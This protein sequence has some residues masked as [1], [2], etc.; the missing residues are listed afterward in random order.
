MSSWKV[1]PALV[2]LLSQVNVLFPS[3]NRAWDGTI[4]D[5]AHAARKSDHDP[6]EAGIVCALDVTNDPVHRLVSRNL[7][8]SIRTAGD[9]RL[10]YVIS[11]REIANMDI[12]SAKWR[13][14]NG[15]N[16]HDHHCHISV[17]QDARLWNDD[18]PWNLQGYILP[19][20]DQI[21]AHVVPPA[22]LKIGSSGSA[23]MELQSL[24]HLKAD[25]QFGSETKAAVQ[26]LQKAHELLD[27]GI[28]GPAT[29]AFLK[30]TKN[31]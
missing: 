30:G 4:G 5:A 3:R 23:V 16:P 20:S 13:P 17:R 18:R 22:M 21:A 11:N 19:T 27:D 25:G 26:D 8:D 31:G 7:A 12:Q 2:T 1:A 24:L 15:A 14:Y 9:A 29:W 10:Q 6:N 28:V